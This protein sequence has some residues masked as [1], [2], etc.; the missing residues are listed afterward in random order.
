MFDIKLEGVEQALKQFDPKIVIRAANSAINDVAKQGK[1]EAE[2]IIKSEYNIKPSRLKQFLKLTSK[3]KG[4]SL[5]AT[6]TGRGLGLALSYFDIKQIGRS[7]RD[8]KIGTQKFK[9]VITKRGQRYGGVVTAL[10]KRSGGRKVVTGKYDN[11]P[12][13]AQM[14]TGHI[15]VWVR[16]D[17]GRKPIEQL[18]G[19]GVGGLFGTLNVMDRTK[20]IIND[21]FAPR[22]SYWLNRYKGDTR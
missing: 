12:F 19:P 15:G 18:Y 8:L 14:K 17:K 20:K 9:S 11:K 10:V 5:E 16:K 6:I 4:N 13:I 2:R 21:K 22:F 3:A 7:I 1:N